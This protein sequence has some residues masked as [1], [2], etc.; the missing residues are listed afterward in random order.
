VD[1]TALELSLRL[2]LAT[3]ALLLPLAVWLGRTLAVQRFPGRRLVEAGILLP[4]VLPPTVVGFYLLAAMAPDAPAG[5][6]WERVTGGSL[7]FT[8]S[9]LL[10]A[11]I[12]VNLPF[13]V[14]PAQRAFESVGQELRDAAA[15]SGLSPWRAFLAVELPLAA[16]GILTGAVLAFAH[17]MGEF[18]VVLMVGGA[19]PGETQTLA[20]SIYDRVQALDMAAAG[21]MAALLVAVSLT[22]VL[23]MF[24]LGGRS[25]LPRG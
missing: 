4:L 3:V 1:W 23:L 13:A 12:L 18:G 25:P 11:S 5:R 2:A 6:L 21:T 22:A 16:P 9:G 7:A 19:I 10:V 8:F 17:A 15:T 14:Q 24:A 20:L